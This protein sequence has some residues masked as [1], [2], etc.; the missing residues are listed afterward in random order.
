VGT[1]RT[2]T[3]HFIEFSNVAIGLYASAAGLPENSV[4]EI[5]NQYA[6]VR[7]NFS[8]T[9]PM[10]DTYHFLRQVNVYDIQA[11]YELVR[12]TRIRDTARQTQ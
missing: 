6:Q 4:L 8:K 2:P 11:G 5:A 9:E 3:E 7:S 12:S 1:D 10:N